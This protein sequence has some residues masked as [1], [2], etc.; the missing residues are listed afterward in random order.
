MQ[1]VLQLVGGKCGA[2]PSRLRSP[3][4]HHLHNLHTNPCPPRSVRAALEQG[5]G[6]LADGGSLCR[7][8]TLVVCQ[9]EAALR[10]L[11]MGVGIVSPTWVIHSLRSGRQ[12]RCLSVSA[13]A[14]R[15]LPSAGP[16]TSAACGRGHTQAGSQSGS[17]GSGTQSQQP[18]LPN[19]LLV[20]KEARQQML[21]QLAGGNSGSATAAALCGASG[22]SGGGAAAHQQAVTPAELLADVLWSVLDPPA[23]ACAEGQRLQRAADPG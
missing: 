22:G 19:E 15:H 20:S 8:V 16:A 3:P 17:G 21:C 18:L 23:A 10:W 1:A 5:G 2:A 9:P 14:S 13:D 12:Q 4:T 7:G 6:Q 11:S